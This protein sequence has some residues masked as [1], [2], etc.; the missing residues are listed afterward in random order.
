M[1]GVIYIFFGL[2]DSDD[3]PN[4]A[5]ENKLT[6]SKTLGTPPPPQNSWHFQRW[7]YKNISVH[8]WIPAKGDFPVL[9]LAEANLGPGGWLGGLA[10]VGS[11]DDPVGGHTPP[12]IG[13]GSH[14]EFV[15]GHW[16]KVDSPESSVGWEKFFGKVSR[17]C[18]TIIVGGWIWTSSICHPV[19][20]DLT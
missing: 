5:S 9:Y 14:F 4:Q 15:V 17:R 1:K 8:T 20:E 19:L 10:V 6:L 16:L 3:K 2:N 11:I 7:P 12:Q 18:Q 13:L